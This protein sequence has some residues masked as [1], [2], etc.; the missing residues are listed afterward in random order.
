MTG[1]YRQSCFRRPTT[2]WLCTSSR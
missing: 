2:Y 1:Y